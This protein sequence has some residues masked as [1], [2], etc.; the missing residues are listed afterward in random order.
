VSFKPSSALTL[1][2]A[3]KPMYA[4]MDYDPENDRFLFTA[5]QGAAAGRVYVIKPNDGNVWDM[6]LLDGGS[7]KIAPSPDNLSGMQN[8]LRYVP[9]LRGF[10][11]LTRASANLYFLRTA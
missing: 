1:W 3:E 8:R 5:G 6:S 7:L 2:L 4:A 10:V 11:M 9:A